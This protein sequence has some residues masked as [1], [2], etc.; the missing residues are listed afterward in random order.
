MSNREKCD[1]DWRALE[2]SLT[3]AYETMGLKVPTSTILVSS[4][5]PVPRFNGRVVIQLDRFMCLGESFKVILEG[6]EIDP[7][8]YDE[9]ICVVLMLFYGKKL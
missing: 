8:D 3:L 5:T 4:S 2:N 9:T 6:C 1:I 7:T